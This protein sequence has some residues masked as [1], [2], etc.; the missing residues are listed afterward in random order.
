MPIEGGMTAEGS[1]NVLLD[2]FGNVFN[3]MTL[4]IGLLAPIILIVVGIKLLRWRKG[5]KR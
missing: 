3:G 2:V 5:R 4:M 1:G